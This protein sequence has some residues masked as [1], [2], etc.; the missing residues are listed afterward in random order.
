VKNKSELAVVCDAGPIIHLDELDCLD[1][2]LDFTQVILP[3]QVRQEI[4]RYRQSALGKEGISFIMI[5]PRTHLDGG[6][7][8]MART[9]M[10]DAGETEA[11]A[12]MKENPNAIFLTDDASVRLVA[13]QMGFKVQGTIGILLRSIRR[14]DRSP[15]EVFR[16]LSDLPEKSSLYIKH[17][18]LDEIILKVK[19][20]FGL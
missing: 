9:F 17:S 14:G 5:A 4:E 16:V 6:L 15:E 10:L 8:T 19:H 18:L 3:G 12:L 11:L 13:K 2:L 7:L 20:E 1:L